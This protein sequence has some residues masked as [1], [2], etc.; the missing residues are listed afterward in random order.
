VFKLLQED[1]KSVLQTDFPNHVLHNATKHASD[2]I[3]VD[4]EMIILKYMD[5]F[6]YQ[7][8]EELS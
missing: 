5:A 3:D 8:K 1:N 4:I 7:Q 2:G 6:W